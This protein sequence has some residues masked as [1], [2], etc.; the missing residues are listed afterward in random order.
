MSGIP[1]IGDIVHFVLDVGPN[2]GEHR[3]AMVVRVRSFDP[4]PQTSIAPEP[5]VVMQVFLDN[6]D[7]PYDHN[8]VGIMRPLSVLHNEKEKPLG[9][10][11]WPE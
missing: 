10:W 3:P 6:H 8:N 2:A 1:N 11:H 4:D 7:L 5:T 9:T